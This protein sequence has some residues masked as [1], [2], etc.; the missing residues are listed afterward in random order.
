MATGKLEILLISF[1]GCRIGFETLVTNKLP[2]G[3]DSAVLM[4]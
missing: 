2:G 1:P 4:L 3:A